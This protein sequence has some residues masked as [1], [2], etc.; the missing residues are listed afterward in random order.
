MSVGTRDAEKHRILH[1]FVGVV[2]SNTHTHTHISIGAPLLF[3][4]HDPNQV[5]KSARLI[6]GQVPF[7]RGPLEGPPG[8][9]GKSVDPRQRYHGS[10]ERDREFDGEA[11]QKSSVVMRQVFWTCFSDATQQVFVTQLKHMNRIGSLLQGQTIL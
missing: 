1:G 6:W 7:S 5:C 9:A 3:C 8:S 10:L 11:H 4:V 2:G